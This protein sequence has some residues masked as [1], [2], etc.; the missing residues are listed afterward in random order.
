DHG[1]AVRAG[2]APGQGQL[3]ADGPP[4]YTRGRGARVAVAGA[5]QA[6]WLDPHRAH[7]SGWAHR[8]VVGGGPDARRL[9]PGSTGPPHRLHDP[10]A[11]EPAVAPARTSTAAG[12]GEKRRRSLPTG[13][14]VLAGGVA[15]GARL[16]R[17]LDLPPPL[18]ARLVG[19]S[20]TT[21]RPARAA[22]RRRRRPT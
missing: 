5:S 4:P 22:G 13:T 2:A 1:C 16:A 10:P 21:A 14:P 12:R 11:S 8:D 9:W 7:V 15:T 3:G 6:W 20:A 18:L 19:A 17:P